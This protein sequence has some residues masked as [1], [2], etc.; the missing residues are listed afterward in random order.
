LVSPRCLARSAVKFLRVCAGN[1]VDNRVY[2]LLI[3]KQIPLLRAADNLLHL[4]AE[5]LPERMRGKIQQTLLKLHAKTDSD[6]VKVFLFRALEHDQKPI[7]EYAS[8]LKY[9]I[10]N[11]NEKVAAFGIV[12]LAQQSKGATRDESYFMT[13][14]EIEQ[15]PLVVRAVREALAGLWLRH[16]IKSPPTAVTASGS[17]LSKLAAI[18][19]DPLEA[20]D[21]LTDVVKH[22]PWYYPALISR[23]Y[24]VAGDLYETA[25]WLIEVVLKRLV[26]ILSKPLRM[27]QSLL[28][29]EDVEARYAA[30]EVSFSSSTSA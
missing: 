17:T 28:D 6:K 9:S 13:L 3:G 20:L 26:E 8:V 5:H 22:Y 15:R 4:S 10:E 16:D 24:R 19:K 27:D 2:G 29:L 21:A 14:L 23:Y 30:I 18:A 12:A 25:P 7:P 11:D 1:K